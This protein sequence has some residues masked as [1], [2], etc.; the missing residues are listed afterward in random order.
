MYPERSD[1]VGS[2]KVRELPLCLGTMTSLETTLK[3]STER[4]RELSVFMVII[5]D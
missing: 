3:L 2:Y 5:E 1:R 4:S